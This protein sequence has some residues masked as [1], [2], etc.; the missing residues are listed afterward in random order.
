MH[1]LSEEELNHLIKIPVDMR[2]YWLYSYVCTGIK[3]EKLIENTSQYNKK[4]VTITVSYYGFKDSRGY[5]K[6]SDLDIFDFKT[7]VCDQKDQLFDRDFALRKLYKVHE[8]RLNAISI[9]FNEENCVDTFEKSKRK[10]TFR[11][12]I[13]TNENILVLLFIIMTIILSSIIKVGFNTDWLISCIIAFVISLALLVL[14]NLKFKKEDK[15]C[16]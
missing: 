2:A 16:E 15:S 7:F 9:G 3:K 4:D 1:N 14:A 8:N 13:F 11:E 5:I 12:K 10:V 6:D